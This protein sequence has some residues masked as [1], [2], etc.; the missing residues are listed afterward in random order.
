A[1][2]ALPPRG[3]AMRRTLLALAL[4]VPAAAQSFVNYETPHVHP[5]DMT[6]DGQKLLAVNT[7]ANTL[8][9]FD[10][11][12]PGLV[13]LGSVPVGLDPCSVRARSTSEAWVCNNISDSVSIVDLATRR[14]KATIKTADEPCDVVF[15]GSSVRAFVSCSEANTVQVW[16][17]A[18]LAAG[19]TNLA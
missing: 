6:P 3:L 17:P 5:L 2:G 4:C 13:P 14:V 19:P 1:R 18:N 10:C 9:I 16:N 7:A 12:G 15:A 11:S 8:E